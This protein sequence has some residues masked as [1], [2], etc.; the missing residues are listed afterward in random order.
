ME[1]RDDAFDGGISSQDR[2]AK[3]AQHVEE[4]ERLDVPPSG[5]PALESSEARIQMCDPSGG[6]I[7]TL[8]GLHGMLPDFEA[9]HEERREGVGE[10]QD[11]DGGDEGGQVRELRD[12][13][14]D[15]EGDDP[16]DWHNAHPQELASLLGQR[17][18]VEHIREEIVV[19]D[20]DTDVAVK[21]GR[22]QRGDESDDV[23]GGLPVVRR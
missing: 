20:L 14:G 1:R 3:C 9:K 4:V 19:K 23:S 22:D 5:K 8:A 7:E 18:K 17:G 11:A 13:G 21:S 6:R 2:T 15:N 16:I 12:R 10:L